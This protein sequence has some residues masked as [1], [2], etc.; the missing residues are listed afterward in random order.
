MAEKTASYTPMPAIPP[1]L[2]TRF[3]AVVKVLAGVT[4]VSAAARS[5]GLSRNHFQSMMHRSLAAMISALSPKPAGRPA[6][7]AREQELLKENARL[8]AEN[9]RLLERTD[10]TDRLLEVASGLL[11]GRVQATGRA[12]RTKGAKTTPKIPSE[13]P[14][15]DDAL[16]GARKM[17]AIGLNM[18]L[19][20]AVLGM[21][22]STLRRWQRRAKVGVGA[23]RVTTN[24]RRTVDHPTATRRVEE[25]VRRT[26]GLVGAAALAHGVEGISRRVAADIK[27]RTLTAMERE[28]RQA[29]GSVVVTQPGV[30]RGFD[31]L[32]ARTTDGLR[33]VLVS[34]DACVP[35]RTSLRVAERY[36]SASVA[37]AIEKDFRD[38]GA[39]L[40]WRADRASCHQTDEVDDVL[41]AWGVLRL[42]GPPHL[43]RFYGQLERQNREHRAWLDAVDVP[44]PEALADVCEEMR[45]ALNDAWPRRTL[46]WMT[47][48]E[49]WATRAELCDARDALRVSV[50]ELVVRLRVE[51]GDPDDLVV[52]RRAIE[53]VLTERG[54]L[55]VQSGGRC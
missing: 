9:A 20:A 46:A 4:T 10:T 5:L 47:A 28:R 24:R 29:C 23:R 37:E 32:W 21:S 51:H 35:Y 25:I 41:S 1:E 36:D 17:R 44:A 33:P 54:Y 52:Q 45:I 43:P 14:P 42:H 40:V 12:P 39:P 30:V 15:R 49:K 53:H 8:K 26:H 6:K 34:A 18:R 50:D 19:V 22:P 13:E 16:E 48:A 11:R 31:Q 27:E 7:P 2:E 38:N 55:R 3:E